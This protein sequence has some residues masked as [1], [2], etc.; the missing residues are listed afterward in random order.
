MGARPH[1]N[2]RGIWRHRRPA[3][4]DPDVKLADFSYTND[5]IAQD[6]IVRAWT[7]SSFYDGLIN[8]PSGGIATRITNA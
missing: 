7:D 8:P 5:E 1:A 4:N 3:H 6:I 2:D